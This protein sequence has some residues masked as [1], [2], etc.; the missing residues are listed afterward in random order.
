MPEVVC[1]LEIARTSGCRKGKGME[2]PGRIV[3][4]MQS[5][6]HTSVTRPRP[7][8]RAAALALAAAATLAWP[9]AVA[10]QETHDHA[11]AGREQYHIN[12]VRADRAPEINGVL[13]EDVW[14]R[15]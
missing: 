11:A 7:G 6:F 14:R 13:D 5:T 15:A 10:G 12:A 9:A 3:A 4:P 8:G 1:F 2:K